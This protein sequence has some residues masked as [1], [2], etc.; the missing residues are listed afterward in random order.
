M[1]QSQAADKR[2]ECPDCR[3]ETRL[4]R[5]DVLF[6]GNAGVQAGCRNCRYSFWVSFT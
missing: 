4:A 5:F 2:V 1:S 6:V 3:Y